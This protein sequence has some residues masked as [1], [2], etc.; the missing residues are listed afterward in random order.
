MDY[1][2]ASSDRKNFFSKLENFG[3]KKGGPFDPGKKFLTTF[4]RGVFGGLLIFFKKRNAYH[5]VA[6]IDAG[7]PT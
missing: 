7:N 2:L 4:F 3:L 5:L 6:K 1:Q